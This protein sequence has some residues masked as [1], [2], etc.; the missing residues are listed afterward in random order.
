VS[1]E[2]TMPEAAGQSKLGMSLITI[3]EAI[4]RSL[5]VVK[6]SSP[7]LA[8]N[9]GP[10]PATKVGF[11][12][13]VR[14]LVSVLNA[15]H[16]TEDDVAF[17]YFRDRI[18]GAPFDALSAQHQEIVPLMYEMQV[19]IDDLERGA[20]AAEAL[21][22]LDAAIARL[23]VIWYPH[24]GVEEHFFDPE[25]LTTKVSPEEDQ[26]ITRLATEHSQKNSGPDYLVVPFI[27]YN[28]AGKRRNDLAAQFPPVVTQQLLPGPWKGEWAAMAPFL[29][30]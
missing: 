13:Y 26:I 19:A 6:T 10:D 12:K 23:V 14:T 18:P 27:L 22:R 17:P 15:H 21:R 7:S 1:K 29:L 30:V 5:E 20:P 3:H 9:G 24:I 16:M 25:V 2:V 4:S 8:L 11:I 28:L